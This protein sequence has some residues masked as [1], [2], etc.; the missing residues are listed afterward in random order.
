MSH[1]Y[2]WS[3]GVFL[4]V[5]L[6][7]A[8]LFLVTHRPSRWYRL[9]AVNVYGWPLLFLLL[10]ARSI[11]LLIVRWPPPD[12]ASW[13]DA[14]IGFGLLVLCDFLLV[15]LLVSYRGFVRRER[16]RDDERR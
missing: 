13:G 8:V 10:Y 7:A 15:A 14:L 9:E 2:G 12:P 1:W 16:R 4:A 11:V 6:V 5:G 3:V